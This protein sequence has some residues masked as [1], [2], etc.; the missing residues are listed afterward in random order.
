MET[1]LATHT[2]EAFLTFVLIVSSGGIGLTKRFRRRFKECRA[3]LRKTRRELERVHGEHR[4]VLEFNFK[5]RWTIRELALMVRDYRKRAG[6]PDGDILLELHEKAEAELKA[7]RLSAS[8]H[9]TS[10]PM[11]E[12]FL[13][14]D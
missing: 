12:E 3:E 4:L 10:S 14:D 13:S 7:R 2:F 1:W 11:I 6:E 9:T 8:L 5:D